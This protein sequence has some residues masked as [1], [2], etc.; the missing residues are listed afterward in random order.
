ML[1]VGERVFPREKHTNWLSNTKLSALKTYMQITLYRRVGCIYILS[2]VH[3]H[4]HI[5][6]YIYARTI[7]EKQS[8]KS[9]GGLERGEGKRKMKQLHNNLKRTNSKRIS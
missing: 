7:K 1:R 9:K 6:M 2:N 5:D 3:V 4:M 8:H